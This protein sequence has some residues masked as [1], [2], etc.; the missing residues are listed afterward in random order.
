MI[1]VCGTCHRM[2]LLSYKIQLKTLV[3]GDWKKKFLLK[4]TKKNYYS[5]AIQTVSIT[6]KSCNYNYFIYK[7]SNLIHTTQK[8]INLLFLGIVIIFC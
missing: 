2:K 4:M 1:T 3:V 7:L 6:A 8:I 5:Y